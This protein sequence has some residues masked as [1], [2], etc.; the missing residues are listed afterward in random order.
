MN[1][2]LKTLSAAA[3]LALAGMSP[4]VAQ[5]ADKTVKIGLIEPMSGNL[6]SYGQEEEPA[7]RRVIDDY[8]AKGGVRSLG[9]AKIEIVVADDSSQPARTAI[10]ARR[11]VGEGAVILA[12]S[13]L[14]P[15]MAAMSPVLDEL[16]VPALSFWAGASRS[17]YLFTLGFPYDTG[18]AGT[19]AGFIN[20]L[21]KDNKFPIKR[22][23]TAFA[24]YEAGQQVNRA[25]ID[26]LT[27]DGFEI[28]GQV[29]LDMNA[30]DYT[31]QMTRIRSMKPDVVVGLVSTR[32]GALLHQARYNLNFTSAIF[33]GGTGGYS[34]PALWSQ[35]GDKIASSVLTQNLF[36]MTGYSAAVAPANAK[37]LASDL[38]Q[39]DPKVR[40][41]QSTFQ[42]AQAAS[43]IIRA[44]E[45]A[46]STDRERL[47]QALGQTSISPGSPDLYLARAAGL[48][49]GEDRML[50]D[51]TAL[52]IQW[53]ADKQQQVV[54]PPAFANAAPRSRQ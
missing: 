34:D 42:A 33:V 6:S 28:V 22:L 36:G 41:G 18:F 21:A 2:K 25:L 12:G 10:E 51:S 48:S 31:A 45:A 39:A 43:I 23:V 37:K 20:W 50:K 13:L 30:S 38:K 9:G 1:R 54:Y 16:K 8:N 46:G 3:L 26:R 53:T 44:L 5:G 17:D 19:M 7:F 40:I 24:N 29:P 47:R 11:L 49:F 32:D 14:T 35:L 52:I 15:H 4:V 27:K